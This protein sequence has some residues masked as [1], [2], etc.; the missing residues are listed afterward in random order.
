MKIKLF[1][2]FW[3]ASLAAC[4]TNTS[5]N[6]GTELNT[7]A[8]SDSKDSTQV[9]AA[10]K[11]NLGSSLIKAADSTNLVIED[12][13][14]NH[15]LQVALRNF[16]GSRAYH[17]GILIYDPSE[18]KIIGQIDTFTPDNTIYRYKNNTN[19]IR[20]L[21]FYAYRYNN[22]KTPPT[23]IGDSTNFTR[24]RRLGD[25]FSNGKE[26]NFTEDYNGSEN[27]NGQ[28]IFNQSPI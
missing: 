1:T 25:L 15:M 4:G 20:R 13:K 24:M 6:E 18:K 3:L 28:L 9:L 12:V 8:A 5:K 21:H 23:S 19:S 14:A 26:A 16:Q 7:S 22:L 17:H 11:I 27:V 2:L 10:Q